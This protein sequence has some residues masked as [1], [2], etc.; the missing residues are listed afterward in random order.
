MTFPAC[1]SH[2]GAQHIAPGAAVHRV[3]SIVILSP[4]GLQTGSGSGLQRCNAVIKVAHLP[5]AGYR[6]KINEL[7]PV[8]N[9]PERASDD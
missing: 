2:K 4:M 7:I 5:V 9:I 3:Q 1:G 8:R 6:Q